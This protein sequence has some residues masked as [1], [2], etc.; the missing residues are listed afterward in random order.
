MSHIR[1]NTFFLKLIEKKFSKFYKLFTL[2]FPLYLCTYMH[3]KVIL[4]LRICVGVLALLF[5]VLKSLREK[6]KTKKLK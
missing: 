5:N 3:L 2:N 6:K 1:E 4:Y